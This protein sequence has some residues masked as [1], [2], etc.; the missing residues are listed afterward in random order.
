MKISLRLAAATGAFMLATAATA[1]LQGQPQQADILG[2]LL[3]A[4]FGNNQQTS[5]QTLETDWNQ[6]RRPFAQRRDQLDA[7]IDNAV[8]NGSLDRDEAEDMRR[9]YDDIVRVEAQYS[10]DGNV[11][12]QQ[13]NDLR[14][15]Y[16]AL[17]QRSGG[18]GNNQ[19]N[20]QGN[21]Q[22][23]DRGNDGRY[24]QDN[25]RWQPVS[26]RNAEFEQRIAAGLRNR[27]LSQTESTR[28]RTEWRTLAQV[29]AEYQRNGL[30]SREQADLWARYNAIDARLSGSVAANN[31]MGNGYGSDRNTVRWSQLETRL[32]TAE[33]NGRISRNEAVMVRSQLNDLAR[34]DT[35]YALNGYSTGERAYL[36]RRY[37]EI[38]TVIGTNRR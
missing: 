18:Q 38:E 13:Q 16:R 29:E 36:T 25:G 35:A 7:R 21:S 12:P 23:D 22:G 2:Q 30:D 20:N 26:M 32:A 8:R 31:G 14:M 19:G 15:R 28:L 33:R 1:Q 6:G 27:T 9:E 11:S 4:V 34:L 24:D 3:G 5:E 37:A 17:M 10:A